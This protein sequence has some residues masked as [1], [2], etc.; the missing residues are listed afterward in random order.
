M[1]ILDISIFIIV[2]VI[3]FNLKFVFRSLDKKDHRFLNKLF[4]F[5]IFISLAFAFLVSQNGGDAQLYWSFPKE[6]SWVDIM[7]VVQRGSASGIIY[8]INYIPSKILDLSFYT[9]NI[10]YGLLGHLGF[11]Y[12]FMLLKNQNY[13][14]L[15]FSNPT[16]DQV[17]KIF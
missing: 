15:G 3:G 14:T 7:D 6:N 13:C 4:A 12:F 16:P 2:L 5:H 1:T 11:V 17:L 10:C 9:G 8:S